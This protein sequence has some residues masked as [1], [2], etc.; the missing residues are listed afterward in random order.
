[1]PLRPCLDCGALSD[2]P[3]C[4]AHRRAR[5]AA[6]REQRPVTHSERLR[7]AETV[8]LWKDTYGDV[9]PGHGV[10]A[11]PSTDLTADH[12]HAV[13]AGGREDQPLTVLC[14]SCNGRK[15]AG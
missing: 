5:A 15:R 13:A 6:K 1:M 4:P 3:R 12:P 8:T 9:C 14:R 7:R 11:H 10:P 2:G